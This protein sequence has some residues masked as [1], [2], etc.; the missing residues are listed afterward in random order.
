M[1]VVVLRGQLSSEPVVRELASG[2]S[3]LSLEVS[4]VTP[5]GLVSVPVA[6][7]DPPRCPVWERGVEVVVAGVVKRRFYR[8]AT[9]TQSR[10]EVVAYEVVEARKRQ[11]VR[12]L[13]E[14]SIQRIVPPTTPVE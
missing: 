3:L 2:S 10:T 4:T 12:R 13:V 7:F 8:S 14:R 11:A 6:W 5:D 1:N 9:G